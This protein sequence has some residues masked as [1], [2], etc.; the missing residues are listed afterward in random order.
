MEATMSHNPMRLS[1]AA[2]KRR[3]T[4]PGKLRRRGITSVLAMMY[5][6]LFS[7]LAVGFYSVASMSPQVAANERNAALAQWAAE[8]GMSFVRQ[9]LW[10]LS[11]PPNTTEDQLLGQVYTDLSDQMDG[12][13]NLA[14]TQIGFGNGA[15][16]IPYATNKIIPLDDKGR[17]FRATITQVGKKLNVKVIGYAGNVAGSARGVQ[18]TYDIAEKAS[19]IF[20]YGLAS[21]GGIQTAGSAWVQGQTDM[22][23]GSVLSALESGGSPT[24]I[25]GGDGISGDVTYMKTAAAP[26]ISAQVGMTSNSASIWADHV[27]AIED[28]P[29]FPTVDTSIFKPYVKRNYVSGGSSG[30]Y[31]NMK[32]PANTNPQFNGGDIVRG[33]LFIERP[34]NVKFNGNVKIEGTIVVDT[35]PTA[36]GNAGTMSTNVISFSGNGGTKSGVETLPVQPQFD[37]LRNLTGSFILAP[38][39]TVDLTGNF[40]SVNGSIVGSKIT[41]DGSA[42]LIVKGTL[43]NVDPNLLLVKG[44]GQVMIASTG[45]TNYPSGLRFGSH[46]F[47]VPGSYREVKP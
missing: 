15:I 35:D 5:L 42:S 24:V 28:S 22:S 40:G 6:M 43:I 31:E 33:V 21:K 39:F 23:K 41:V 29:E 45:T 7:A 3:A 14:G 47:P 26:V 16:T 13:P 37:G 12:T 11:V 25:I 32:I 46:Y 18:L 30:V 8:S 27:H 10:K 9:Q 20:D 4:F 17:G 1:G 2:S 38:G 19:K 36:T 44:N 34:N